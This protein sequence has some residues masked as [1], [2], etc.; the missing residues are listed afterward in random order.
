MAIF[1]I[2]VNMLLVLSECQKNYQRAAVM[3]FERYGIE[4]SHMTFFNL[5]KRLREHGELRKK[6][7]TINVNVLLIRITM[8]IFLLQLH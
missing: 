6:K 5:E 7:L 4:K 8:P 1:D 2:E 3:F